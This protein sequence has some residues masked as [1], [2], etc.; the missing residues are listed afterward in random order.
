MLEE[1]KKSTQSSMYDSLTS[2]AQYSLVQRLKHTLVLLT[3]CPQASPTSD[4][5]Q[6]I[7]AIIILPLLWWWCSQC[8]GLYPITENTTGSSCTI[9]VLHYS[10]GGTL[11]GTVRGRGVARILGKGV[12]SMR[13]R[14]ARTNLATP[15]YEMGRSKLKLSQRMRSDSS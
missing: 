1:L 4:I 3:V 10:Q 13:M 14:I 5:G 8:M 2:M 9:M 7:T 15:T 12:L 6:I 11:D